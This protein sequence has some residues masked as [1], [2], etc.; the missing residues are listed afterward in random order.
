MAYA[1]DNPLGLEPSELAA[2]KRAK[3]AAA[4]RQ[5]P[6]L[7]GA[8][9]AGVLSSGT[10]TTPSSSDLNK[11]PPVGY[12]PA[13]A[14]AM[15]GG[16]GA[17]LFGA[18]ETD[19][20]K[21]AVK[22]P[23]VDGSTS[24]T[25]SST[26]ATTSST[27]ATTSSTT[28]PP[29]V[30]DPTL[31]DAYALLEDAFNQYGLGDLASVIKGYMAQG[32]GPNEA[33]LLL[34]QNPIYQQRFAGLYDKNFGRISNGLNAISEAEYLA[35][36]NSYNETLNAYGLNNYFGKDA[37]AKQAGMAAIIGGDVSASEFANR[38]KLAQDQVVNADPQVMAT[39]KQFYPS[40]N[41]TDLLKYYLDPKQNL[42]ALTEK[43]TAAQIGTAAIEQGLGTNVTSATDLA[44][45]GV[46]QAGAQ[47][48]YS[49][50]GEI[51]PTTTKLSGIYGEANVGYN[52]ATAE[53]EIFKGSAS[54]KRKRDQLAQLEQAAFSGRSGVNAAVN[55]LG[56]GLQ[57]S[58]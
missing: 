47:A 49:K 54:A 50:I 58:F 30:T 28:P 55:P 40:I 2:S 37:K 24:A 53:E 51:L 8:K 31:K 39:L 17:P 7:A 32:I 19:T 3:E 12:N 44:K 21:G 11:F 20:S 43:T 45:Y 29:A 57:G 10:V 35:L 13:M 33:K 46:T 4:A 38:V 27:S 14:A 25:T 52:Q 34:K 26:S 6:T 18:F 5:T 22:L 41:D 15:P 42:A 56:K 16:L 48:G 36:E 1:A 9:A 23:V